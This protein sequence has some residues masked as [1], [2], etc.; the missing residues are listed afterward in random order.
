MCQHEEDLRKLNYS[1][2]KKKGKKKERKKASS[3]VFEAGLSK[4]YVHL[5]INSIMEASLCC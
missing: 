4:K 3:R 5:Q 1:L 2:K